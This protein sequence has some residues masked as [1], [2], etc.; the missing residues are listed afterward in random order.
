MRGV[1]QK[2]RCITAYLRILCGNKRVVKCGLPHCNAG[3]L[4]PDDRLSGQRSSHYRTVPSP[5]QTIERAMEPAPKK[6]L[7]QVS[8]AI[9]LLHYSPR[10]DETYV[11]WIRRFIRSQQPKSVRCEKP[12]ELRLVVHQ[13]IIEQDQ[14]D[15]LEGIAIPQRSRRLPPVDCIGQRY[16]RQEA[17]PWR[18]MSSSRGLR[19]SGSPSKVCPVSAREC[20]I[21]I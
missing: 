6:L 19:E 10:T 5:C 21:R 16:V 4:G 11:H 17:W 20:R 8:D 12:E 9:H 7:E 15:V 1:I 14:Q 13:G 3:C 2:F 18:Q